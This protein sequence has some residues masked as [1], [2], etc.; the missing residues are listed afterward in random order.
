MHWSPIY[1]SSVN[2]TCGAW[3][4]TPNSFERTVLPVHIGLNFHCRVGWLIL[5]YEGAVVVRGKQLSRSLTNRQQYVYRSCELAHWLVG[6]VT[7]ETV[8]FDGVSMVARVADNNSSVLNMICS[9]WRND[10]WQFSA[11][12]PSPKRTKQKR[13]QR[14]KIRSCELGEEPFTHY[15]SEVYVIYD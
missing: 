10:K 15:R 9:I 8:A 1:G 5:R 7:P 3:V 14:M 11:K 13:S 12:K 6:F 2:N 4:R